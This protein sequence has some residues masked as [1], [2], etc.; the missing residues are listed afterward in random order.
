MTDPIARARR[1]EVDEHGGAEHSALDRERCAQIVPQAQAV[2]RVRLRI[3]KEVRLV[4]HVVQHPVA[5]DADARDD[6]CATFVA[7]PVIETPKTIDQTAVIA[8]LCEYG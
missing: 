4:R 5:R 2:V 8:R 6:A 3:E 1:E 7:E